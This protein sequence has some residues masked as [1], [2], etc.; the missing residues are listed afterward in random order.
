MRNVKTRFVTYLGLAVFLLLS[1]IYMLYKTSFVLNWNEF[2]TST[3]FLN[4]VLAIAFFMHARQAYRQ[5]KKV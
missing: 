1:V 5:L 4:T 3:I 2:F